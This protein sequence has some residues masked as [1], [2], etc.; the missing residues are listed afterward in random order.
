MISFEREQVP[1][2]KRYAQSTSHFFIFVKYQM[3]FFNMARYTNYEYW[4][5]L[6][7]VQANSK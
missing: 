7:P 5:S 4:N 1:F 3:F 6:K 2:N